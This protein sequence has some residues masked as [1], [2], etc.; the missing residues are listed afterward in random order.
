MKNKFFRIM[1]LAITFVLLIQLNSFATLGKLTLSVE[2]DKDTYKVNNKVV[3]TIK[4]EKEVESAGFVI[5]YDENKLSF[6][7]TSVGSNYYNSDT[8]GKILFN[9]AAFDGRAIKE[10]T[11]ILKANTEGDTTII[12]QEA[13]GFADTLLK[14]ATEYEY[15]NKKITITKTEEPGNTQT[16]EENED[17]TTKEE[18]SNNKTAPR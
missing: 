18:I 17:T 13:K 11:F 8:A 12:V 15:N 14:Q 3:V 10:V 16:P 5:K 1:V 6:D 7:S 9:W 2:T 4:W